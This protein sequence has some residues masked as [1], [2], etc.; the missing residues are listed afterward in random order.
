MTLRL[1][2][3][4]I[5]NFKSLGDVELSFRDLTI[6]VGSNSSGKSNSLEALNLLKRLL[7][8]ESLP[9]LKL[10]KELLRSGSDRISIAIVVED[11]ENIAEYTVAISLDKINT[12]IS[13]ENLKI[14]GIKIIDIINGEGEVNDEDGSNHQQYQSDP[15]TIEGLALR[16]AGNFGNKPLTKRLVSYIKEWKFYDI[17]PDAIRSR[18]VISILER[19]STKIHNNQIVPNLDSQASKVQ[20][21]LQYLAKNEI[22]K[23]EA[24]SQEISE[25]LNIR[26]GL[27]E[28]DEDIKIIEVDEKEIPLSNM[29]DGTLRLIAYFIL[30]Y[31]SDIPPLISIEEPER[32]LHP[33]I[34]INLSSIMKRL[35]KRTQVVFTTHSSQL[36][37]CFQAD[38]ISSDISVLL[39]SKKSELGTE[40]F[41][42]DEL[43]EK[44]DD[45]LDWMNDFGLGSAIYHSH[46]IEQIL[47]T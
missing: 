20:E 26:L 19:I 8:A 29:S 31:Q 25:C 28:E 3:A 35:S 12:L 9:S 44:R 42:L 38:E 23:F 6:I 11:N 1:R 13:R 43:A 4:K 33:G 18:N 34:L 21:I 17:D 47:G 14:N 22:D 15:E 16:A 40:S 27:N 36:L 24:I 2:S 39:L 30:L 45:L 10:M 46:L 37:D 7:S 32:N 41:L 5:R